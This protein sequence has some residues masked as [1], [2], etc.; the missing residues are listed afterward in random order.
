M[1]KITAAAC[2]FFC[3]SLFAANAFADTEAYASLKGGKLSV[4]IISDTDDT[5]LY[6]IYLTEK[7][8]ELAENASGMISGGI[9]L[10]Q[11]RLS[12]A[13]ES[14]YNSILINR[15]ANGIL[16]DTVYNVTVGGGELDGET[17]SVIYP[18]E[19]VYGSALEE[20]RGASPAEV[21]DI[22]GK[23]QNKAWTLDLEDEIYTGSRDKVNENLVSIIKTADVVEDSFLK[24]SALAQISECPENDI[25]GVLS[26]Y[27]SILGADY[28]KLVEEKNQ[29]VLKAFISL[30]NDKASNPITNVSEFE[31]ILRKSEAL[32]TLNE[33]SRDE[34]INIL[35]SFNDVFQLDWSGDFAQ[36]DSYEFI[37]KMA[38][39]EAPYTSVSQVR[40][41]FKSVVESLYRSP[42]GKPHSSGGG[43]GGGGAAPSGVGVL[44]GQLT[45]EIVERVNPERVFSDIDE[46]KWGKPY[47]QYLLDR[48]IMSGDG[49]NMVRPAD[50]V[51]REEFLK[52]LIEALKPA[53]PESLPGISFHDVDENEWYAQYIAKAVALGIVKGINE[54][55]FGTGGS[56][57][58]QD[59]AV[60]ICRG[61]EAAK[62]V[63]NE[64]SPPKDF[65]DHEDI[66]EYALLGVQKLQMA[67]IISG[68]E[69]GCFLP[70][71]TITRA[72]AAKLIYSTL[73]NCGDL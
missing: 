34:I 31:A 41:K 36:V 71:N 13:A 72:E 3:I 67:D 22:L 12:P 56:I 54:N 64:S 29:S 47:I 35:K 46:V 48:N 2:V 73:K 70:Q 14:D 44:S 66:S 10:E 21:S 52:M 17:I 62:K 69:T 24:A 4:N 49:N 30:R 19:A 45:P 6:T 68:Y 5:T 33:A 61:A 50:T 37:K 58:R 23:Y 7:D 15:N 53:E 11:A 28:P 60:M 38:P 65:T 9:L 18:S 57:T 63:I 27:K 8:A 32:G 55:T 51:K 1:K 43:G 25:Y 20:L 39:G 42:S 40:E 16:K 59:A 26:K